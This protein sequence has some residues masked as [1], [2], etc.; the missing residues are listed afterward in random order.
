ME[1]Q[2]PQ[3]PGWATA[4]F[5]LGFFVIFLIVPWIMARVRADRDRHVGEPGSD[6]AVSGPVF[7]SDRERRLWL[8]LLA[9]LMVI[10]ST[11]GLVRELA[12]TLRENNL[13]GLTSTA[14]L[15]L[16]GVAIAV[17]WAKTR[18]GRYEIVTGA[19]SDGCLFDGGGQDDHSRAH[20]PVRVRPGGHP[21]LSGSHRASTQRPSSPAAGCSRDGGDR[22]ARLARRGVPDA[23]SRPLL[24]HR[25]RPGQCRLGC[26]SDHVEPVLGV[27]TAV[28][29][30]DTP[31][32]IG[33]RFVGRLARRVRDGSPAVAL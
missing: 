21:H 18:P 2:S 29:R 14:V 17:R 13:L 26:G 19:R 4:L 33:R 24:R 12:L 32:S 31:V 25:R 22:A 6:G 9:V 8:C 10:Y 7:S 27:G 5:F 3:G 11:M 16:A 20:L 30:A 1:S 15:L 23:A 28:R